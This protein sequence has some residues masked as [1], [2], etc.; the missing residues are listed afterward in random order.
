MPELRECIASGLIILWFFREALRQNLDLQVLDLWAD[1]S[2]RESQRLARHR[3]VIKLLPSSNLT[4]GSDKAQKP[5]YPPQFKTKAVLP[6][7][8]VRALRLIAVTPTPRAVILDFGPLLLRIAYLTHCSVQIYPRKAWDEIVTKTPLPL[9]RPGPVRNLKQKDPAETPKRAKIGLG[10]EF[11]SHVLAFVT[12]DLVFEPRWVRDISELQD[13]PADVYADY[14]AF[15]TTVAAWIQSRWMSDRNSLAADVIRT[16][17]RSVFGGVGV[18][19]VCEIFFDAGLNILLTEAEIFTSPS[20]T[21][22]L[23]EA[24]WGYAYKSHKEI[25]N[26]LKPAWHQMMLAPTIDQRLQ[27]GKWLHVYAQQRSKVP[28]RLM[29]LIGEYQLVLDTLM[30][31]EDWTLGDASNLH[32][33]FDPYWIKDALLPPQTHA[34]KPTLSSL[35]FGTVDSK[36]LFPGLAPTSTDPLTL[37]YSEK[38]LLSAPTYLKPGHYDVLLE[39]DHRQHV[40]CPTFTFRS[41]DAGQKQLWTIHP[42]F[43]DNSVLA[44]GED[45]NAHPLRAGYATREETLALKPPLSPK[46]KK[47]KRV[48][49]RNPPEAE[50]EGGDEG[51]TMDDSSAPESFSQGSVSAAEDSD[52]LPTIPCSAEKDSEELPPPSSPSASSSMSGI[53]DDGTPALDIPVEPPIEGPTL[54]RKRNA[55]AKDTCTSQL[56]IH[57]KRLSEKRKDELN[58]TQYSSK[59]SL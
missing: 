38:G 16:H 56:L 39:G 7:P 41:C 43:P 45:R 54:K 4:R 10:I 57:S 51:D 12:L 33:I 32:D 46:K 6:D 23:C 2:K 13:E 53:E 25:P 21:A 52:F 30:L 29:S 31:E 27:Y 36:A 1:V 24:L 5:L 37:F 40:Y 19:T 47:T 34:T 18:Y 35:I 59:R 14:G 28:P 22:R 55:W 20:R 17:G 26:L 8:P 3:N 50:V 15:L 42:Q 44:N 11:G 48:R 58:S 49:V 9:L